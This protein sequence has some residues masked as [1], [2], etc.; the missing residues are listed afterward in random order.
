MPVDSSI[1]IKWMSPFPVEGES[2]VLFYFYFQWTF[3]YANS[4]DPDQTPRSPTSDLGI[5]Y[6]PRFQ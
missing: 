3:L 2:G 4:V 6:L 5:H 1:L